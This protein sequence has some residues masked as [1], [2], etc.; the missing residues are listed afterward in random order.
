MFMGYP[1]ITYGLCYIAPTCILKGYTVATF[2]YNV[3][4]GCTNEAN[5]FFYE[6]N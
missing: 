5:L 4:M 2:S 1:L 3:A 6:R